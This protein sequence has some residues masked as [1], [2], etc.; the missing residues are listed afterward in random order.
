MKRTV[1]FFMIF[2]LVFVQQLASQS[3]SDDLT[4]EIMLKKVIRYGLNNRKLVYYDL[5]LFK[6]QDANAGKIIPLFAESNKVAYPPRI[7]E[8][9]QDVI[10]RAR[11]YY[12]DGAYKD[13]ADA[14]NSVF[15]SE[16]E[17]TFYIYE[18]GLTY[19]WLEGN[20]TNSYEYLSVLAEHLE[21]KY[22][23]DEQKTAIDFTYHEL[24]WKLGTLCLDYQDY[25]NAVIQLSKSMIILYSLGQDKN[26]ELDESNLGFLAEAFSLTQNKE[27]FDYFYRFIKRKYPNDK[28]VDRFKK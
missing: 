28:Y 14:Y 10:D 21:K 25:T 8:F 22:K 1:L 7:S 11:G 16:K 2:S 24:Y 5:M 12:R 17:N 23:E 26:K 18:L 20:R 6:D 27:A 4:D 15:E 9:H 19:Y 13:A 3:R